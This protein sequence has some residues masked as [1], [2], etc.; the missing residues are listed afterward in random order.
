M[1]KIWAHRGASAYAPENTLEAFAL[2]IEM[3]ADGIELD[4]HMTSDGAVVVS[5]DAT[6][7]RCSDG[8]GKIAEMTFA[9]LREYSYEAS[10]AGKYKNVKI[11]TLEEVYKLIEPTNMV[12]NVEIK[13]A[14]DEFIGRVFDAELKSGMRDRII[15]SS[16]NHSCLAKMSELNPESFTAPLYNDGIAK[17]WEYAAS[18][19]A[20]ALHPHYGVVY[21]IKNYIAQAHEAGIRVHPWTV[22]SESD[23]L[24]LIEMDADAIITNRP[25]LGVRLRDNS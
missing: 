22:D 15:Y 7:D 12:V 18:F 14:G 9:K 20:K 6:I 1:T 19:G 3:K 17:P 8:R 24:R 10:F 25:D 5:H 16:F 4:V 2:A 13:A 23:I 11:P 21:A